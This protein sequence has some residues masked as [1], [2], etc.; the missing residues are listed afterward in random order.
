MKTYHITNHSSFLGTLKSALKKEKNHEFLFLNSYFHIGPIS[1]ILTENWLKN[2]TDWI[3]ENIDLQGRDIKKFQKIIPDYSKNWQYEQIQNFC[4]NLEKIS[5]N[6]KIFVYFD[7]NANG[8]LFFSYFCHI[9]E[10]KN[11]FFV[12]Y[13]NSRE[14]KLGYLNEEKISEILPLYT[15]KLTE[16]RREFYKN[17]LKEIPAENALRIAK[18]RKIEFHN[19]EF[20]DEKILKIIA[21]KKKWMAVVMV[22]CNVF[23]SG[24]FPH[25]WADSTIFWQI[26]RLEKMW[27]IEFF[28]KIETDYYGKNRKITFVKIKNSL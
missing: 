7:S 5:E 9:F 2:Y 6:D 20:F 10:H 11:I 14:K 26:W 4:K 13:P 8:I 28:T 18:N 17:F 12:H 19:A 25:D 1:S 27:K 16:K 23:I 22:V 24:K 3:T 15:K 21:K